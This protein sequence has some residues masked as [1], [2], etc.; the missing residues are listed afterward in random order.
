MNKT[1]YST[2]LVAL[3][4]VFCS[5]ATSFARERD[6]VNIVCFGNSTTAPRKGLNKPYPVLLDEKLQLSGI[7]AQ[8]FNAGVPGSHAGSRS[9]NSFHKV[10]HALDRFDTAVMAKNPDWVI[11]SFGINDSWQDQGKD[12]PARISLDKF[13]E[14]LSY[15]IEKI[16]DAHGKAILMTPNPLGIKFE[17]YRHQQLKKYRNACLRVARKH[18]IEA[19]DSWGIFRRQSRNKSN[20]ID[21]LLMDGM[22]PNDAGHAL[23]AD[24]VLQ[25]ISKQYSND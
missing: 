17:S 1:L 20:G 3:L 19:V 15:F 10:A 11:I 16:Q 13:K 21:D 6:S 24:A 18:N 8:I 23:M 22:H 9:E 14:H 7:K 2:A 4:M 12:S 25:I 5:C